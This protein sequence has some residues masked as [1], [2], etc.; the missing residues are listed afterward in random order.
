M[1]EESGDP[2]GFNAAPWVARWLEEPLAAL[3]G[4]KPRELM[5]TAEGQ[6]VVSNMLAR[7][8]SGAYA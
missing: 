4:R 1:V 2:R 7:A 8:Q 5:D 3:G 6:A